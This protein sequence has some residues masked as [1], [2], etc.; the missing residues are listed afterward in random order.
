MKFPFTYAASF[1]LAAIVFSGCNLH[2][3]DFNDSATLYADTNF[4]GPKDDWFGRTDRCRNVSDSMNDRASS[5]T[6]DGQITVYEDENCGGAWRRFD[7]NVAD[8]HDF[9]WGDRISS[10]RY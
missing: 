2:V 4:R 7:C 8:L 6:C 1:S 10:I 9:G 3:D 5:L